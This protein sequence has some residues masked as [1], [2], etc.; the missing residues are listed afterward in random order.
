[1]GDFRRLAEEDLEDYA[2]IVR[3]AY[4]SIGSRSSESIAEY[5]QKLADR[6]ENDPRIGYHGLY[7]DGRMLGGLYLND[8][9]MNFRGRMVPALGVSLV[10]V[11]LAHKRRHVCKEMM[12]AVLRRMEEGDYALTTL[13]PFRADFYRRMGFGFGSPVYELDL[14]PAALPRSDLRD[15]VRLLDGESASEALEL[16]SEMLAGTNGLLEKREQE[17]R[18][19]VE[20]G[21]ACL[22]AYG[23]AG[24]VRGYALFRFGKPPKSNF[25]LYDLEVLEL[26]H[27]GPKALTGL[28]AFLAAQSDQVRR[29]RIYTHDLKLAYRFQN[30]ATRDRRLL[31]RVHHPVAVAG[32]GVMYRFA[33]PGETLS[34]FASTGSAESIPPV[35]LVVEDDFIWKGARS[36]TLCE[37]GGS[38]T[39][40][41][42]APTSEIRVRID[43]FSSL[44]AGSM[45]LADL[46]RLGIAECRGDCPVE[47]LSRALEADRPPVCLT[48][49]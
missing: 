11:D 24:R 3:H 39:M 28:L 2:R 41:Q 20:S 25:L 29:I 1:M 12:E 43:A 4:P 18:D 32:I 42:R 36:V 45:T 16:Y 23:E 33:D 46:V 40:C 15:R 48:G 14:D 30:P 10:A 17:L 44:A 13:Y 7:R 22:A 21:N 5:A 38:I 9:R 34:L 6:A 37:E 27:D 8:F 47:E 35:E 31:P 19:P 49:F 26:V